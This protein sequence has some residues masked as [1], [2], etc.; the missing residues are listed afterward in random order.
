MP[1]ATGP[2]AANTSPPIDRETFLDKLPDQARGAVAEFLETAQDAGA[3]V[4]WQTYGPSIKVERDTTRQV[5]YLETKRLGVTIQASGGFPEAP[6]AAVAQRLKTIGVGQPKNWWH[7]AGWHEMTDGQ[8][9]D[10]LAA[11]IDLIA[12]LL[13]PTSWTALEPAR[14][15]AFDRND[16]NL[17][18]KSVPSL[19]DLQGS[20]LRGELTRVLSG[21]TS[22]VELVPL[23][24]GAAGW[25]PRI[26]SVP[27]A[28]MWPP[29]VY[30][31]QYEL[32]LEQVAADSGLP[33]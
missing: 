28:E 6:F 16:H 17:W 8:A 18:I 30:E 23:K 19:S 5:A 15:V 13:P 2:S 25:R 12:G 24:A 11:V 29:N 31:G 4:T 7:I 14:S 10:A 26:V 33:I 20:S 32:R 22:T 9:T 27:T 3:H 21:K 1:A